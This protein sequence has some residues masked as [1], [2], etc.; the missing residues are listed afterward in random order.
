MGSYI[1]ERQR[2]EIEAYLKAGIKPD[3]IADFLGKCIGTI[4]NEIKRGKCKQ[5]TSN[6][7]EKEI[8]LADVAQRK[9]EENKLNKGA[10]LKIGNDITFCQFIEK[11]IKKRKV[12]TVRGTAIHKE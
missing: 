8:Y 5:I 2:Y 10:S 4:Y 6:L 11:K 3:K 12:F 7:E 9:Y 1:T